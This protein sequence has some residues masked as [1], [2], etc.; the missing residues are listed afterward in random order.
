MPGVPAPRDK[1][2]V[3]GLSSMDMHARLKALRAVK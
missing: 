2:I 3:N 1:D